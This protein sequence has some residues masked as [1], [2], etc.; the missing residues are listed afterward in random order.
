MFKNLSIKDYDF[1]LIF[2]VVALNVC[3]L[4]AVNSANSANFQ[5]QLL[6][7]ILGFFLMIVLSFMDLKL[8]IKFNWLWYLINLALLIAVEIAGSTGG[9]SQRW[10]NIAGITFQPS[11]T[12]KIFLIVIFAGLI[13]KYHDKVNNILFLVTYFLLA[14]IPLYLVYEQPDFSTTI[15][16]VIL[17]IS[18]LFVGGIA[19]K[20]ILAALAVMVPTL[21][22]FL[23]IVLKE[24]QT[25]IN[26]YQRNRIMSFIYPEK[27]ADL[28]YQQNN[29][30][31]A[32][33]SGCLTGKGLNNNIISSLKNGNYIIAP[34]TDFI[35]AVI[36]EETGFVGSFIVILLIFLIVFEC[37]KIARTSPDVSG[38]AI[39]AGMASLIGF[40]AFFNIG[41]ATF[42]LPNTG[43]TLPFVSYGLT[44]LVSSYIGMGFVLNIKL[45]SHSEK[46][47][48]NKQEVFELN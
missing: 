2:F 20:Y 35:F 22:V 23:S 42:L 47:R 10:F 44:S 45:N 43:L 18:I 48:K 12:C 7:S 9:G 36:G 6:G 30:V 38:R 3:G 19:F 4:L 5:K 11:E 27:Y 24:S 17:I 16:L 46:N 25:L 40:Q 33:G 13:N 41:V 31:I 39:A 14:A 29:S 8:I 1:K 21:I 28:A 32:I 34:D 26:D 37:L 15:V